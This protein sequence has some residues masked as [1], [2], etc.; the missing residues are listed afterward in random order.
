MKKNQH[1]PQYRP[2]FFYPERVRCHESQLAAI[3]AACPTSF[4]ETFGGTHVR[5]DATFTGGARREEFDAAFEAAN[6]EYVAECEKWQK[7][8]P[9][10]AWYIPIPIGGA[11]PELHGLWI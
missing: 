11:S 7:L 1:A 6:A 4:I 2:E 3:Q 9:P 8:P 5:G 10:P